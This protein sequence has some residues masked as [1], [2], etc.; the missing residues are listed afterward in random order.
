MKL[1]DE[2]K[3]KTVQNYTLQEELTVEKEVKVFTFLIIIIFFGFL[4]RV[5]FLK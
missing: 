4:N 5:L 2:I 1:F 3:F